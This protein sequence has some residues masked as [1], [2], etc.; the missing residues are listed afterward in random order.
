MTSE[1]SCA[2]TPTTPP[3]STVTPTCS[4]DRPKNKLKNRSCANRTDIDRTGLIVIDRT[5]I[6]DLPDWVMEDLAD[7]TDIEDLAD[8]TDIEDLA[9]RLIDIV[10]VIGVALL[11]GDF[12]GVFFVLLEVVS[13]GVCDSRD[14]DATD[15]DADATDD[16]SNAIDDA[17]DAIDGA[18]CCSGGILECG[19]ALIFFCTVTDLLS[20]F[21]H[22]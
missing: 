15:G 1:V 7:R 2:A 11:V 20:L 8:R 16:A 12:I 5:D 17:S 9:D 22:S 10:N 14:A 6:E 3:S 4:D 21:F 18:R 19:L 13:V